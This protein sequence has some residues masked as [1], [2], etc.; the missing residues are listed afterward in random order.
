M[1]NVVDTKSLVGDNCWYKNN[2][3]HREDGPANI[4]E[5]GSES[6]YFEGFRHREGGPAFTTPSGYKSWWF[7]GKRHRFDGPAIIAP[8]GSKKWFLH[9]ESLSKEQWWEK[10]SDDQKLK[11]LFNGEGYE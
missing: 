5:D 7:M 4:G 9:D 8:N 2:L 10:L 6:W 3:L 1:K 11:A